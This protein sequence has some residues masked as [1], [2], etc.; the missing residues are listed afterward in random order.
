LHNKTGHSRKSLEH[1]LRPRHSAGS[2]AVQQTKLRTQQGTI[3]AFGEVREP[4]QMSH[5]CLPCSHQDALP[6]EQKFNLPK[7]LVNSLRE[8]QFSSICPTGRSTSQQ[9]RQV[10]ETL[11]Q[12]PDTVVCGILKQDHEG[13]DSQMD[14]SKFHISWHLCA[15]QTIDSVTS[16]IQWNPRA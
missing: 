14:R 10:A 16:D 13:T 9:T 4:S 11:Q 2:P 3:T 5:Q 15:G 7:G 8:R 6:M 12:D 1:D